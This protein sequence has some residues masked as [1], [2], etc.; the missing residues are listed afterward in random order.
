MKDDT[1]TIAKGIGIFLVVLGHCTGT[2]Q[3]QYIFN[4]IYLFHMP[5]FFFLSGYF[6]KDKYLNN[7][8]KFFIGRLRRLYVPFVKWNVI[9]VVLHNFFYRIYIYNSD[10]GFNG[11]PSHLYNRNDFVY[12]IINII[13]F[14]N[15]E[16]LLGQLW[17]LPVLFF[18]SMMAIVALYVV[19]KTKGI[20]TKTLTYVVI[21]FLLSSLLFMYEKIGLF[22]ITSMSLLATS[23]YLL[24]YL[25]KQIKLFNKLYK[26]K[27]PIIL[28]SIFILAIFSVARPLSL[29]SIQTCDDIFYIFI[30]SFIG[31]IMIVLLSSVLNKFSIRKFFIY[32][33]D[34]TMIILILHLLFFKLV[35]LAKIYYYSDVVEKIAIIPIIKDHNSFVWIILYILSGILF[36]LYFQKGFVKLKK[37]IRK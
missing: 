22:Y 1:F 31:I 21:L 25:V 32:I 26:Y 23:I 8:K 35:N 28:F 5:L 9:F 17:F 19:N 6:F 33:G 30:I 13:G 36:P 3:T 37:C 10:Y 16:P 20:S 7:K 29:M 4:F 11:I 12:N 14:R 18:S 2:N 34:N 27:V 24:G 15:E